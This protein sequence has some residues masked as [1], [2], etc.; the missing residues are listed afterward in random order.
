MGRLRGVDSLLLEGMAYVLTTHS[1]CTGTRTLQLDNDRDR[2]GKDLAAPKKKDQAAA[3]G[4]DTKELRLSMVLR[5]T[6]GHSN[7]RNSLHHFKRCSH[8]QATKAT[9]GDKKKAA[10]KIWRRQRS[11]GV[12]EA[13]TPKTCDAKE[14]QRGK[15]RR[16]YRAGEGGG[17]GRGQRR[18]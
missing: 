6:G 12:T 18:W 9:G 1:R 13:K 16:L 17:K 11:G 4:D 3:R 7:R 8:G 2:C 10:A 14:L 15:D 5:N